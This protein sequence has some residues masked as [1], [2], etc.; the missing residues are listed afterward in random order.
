MKKTSPIIALGASFLAIFGSLAIFA[1]AEA[2]TI[3]V[4][5]FNSY[6]DGAL[7]GQGDW[8]N[9]LWSCDVVSGKV[10]CDGTTWGDNNKSGVALSSGDMTARV[11][12]VAPA[13]PV[14]EKL[15]WFQLRLNAIVPIGIDFHY[16]NDHPGQIGAIQHDYSP[17]DMVYFSIGD[18][19]TVRFT[20][21]DGSFSAYV[22]DILVFTNVLSYDLNDVWFSLRPHSQKNWEM[23]ID[24]IGAGA[25]P[26]ISGYA[27]I[28]T[29]VSPERNTETIVD[30]DDGFEVAG[31]VQIPTS[32]SNIYTDLV[33]TFRAPDSFL[34]AETY[35]IDM[36]N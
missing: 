17:E 13:D 30:F 11:K 28:L 18:W 23:W 3:L 15:G 20:W 21:A 26:P 6:S 35:V 29:P 32:N 22:D 1:P 9:F 16:S 10:V 27:P 36:A 31:T 5:D 12:F 4:D 24:D 7:T 25:P 19:H 2:A 34:P 8:T 33:L 14:N